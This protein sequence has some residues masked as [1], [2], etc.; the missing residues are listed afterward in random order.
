MERT[1]KGTHQG[2]EKVG[3]KRKRKSEQRENK[4]RERESGVE[5]GE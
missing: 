4:E 3:W 5:V 2:R 1:K